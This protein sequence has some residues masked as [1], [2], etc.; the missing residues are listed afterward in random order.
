MLLTLVTSSVQCRLTP[1]IP[2]LA[3]TSRWSEAPIGLFRFK[4]TDSPTKKPELLL[5]KI[6]TRRGGFGRVDLK[7]RFTSSTQHLRRSV[8]LASSRSAVVILNLSYAR[9]R[10]NFYSFA[11]SKHARGLSLS[12][13]LAML[14]HNSELILISLCKVFE[15]QNHFKHKVTIRSLTNIFPRYLLKPTV[16]IGVVF[17]VSGKISVSGNARTRTMWW[18]GGVFSNSRLYQNGS[19]SFNIIR[20]IT[21]CLGVHFFITFFKMVA[22]LFLV[23]LRFPRFFYL[24]VIIWVYACFRLAFLTYK[25]GVWG[26]GALTGFRLVGS[27]VE[28]SRTSPVKA[29]LLSF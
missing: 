13:F 4:R 2:H 29:G 15:S 17:I 5:P 3:L 14:N 9:R 18:S 8:G 12:V 7:N 25:T 28:A 11:F 10:H 16:V 22:L 1:A 23:F 19:Y 26:D 27:I 6:R 24:L 20:T 21:G